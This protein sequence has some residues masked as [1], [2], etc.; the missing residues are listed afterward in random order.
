MGE[1][2]MYSVFWRMISDGAP[3]SSSISQR[4]VPVPGTLLLPLIPMSIALHG[5]M[6]DIKW[7]RLLDMEYEL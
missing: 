1:V 5:V 7:S 4:T 6:G 2:G 3:K